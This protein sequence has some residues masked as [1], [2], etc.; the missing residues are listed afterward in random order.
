M[1]K[2]NIIIVSVLSIALGAGFWTV[3]Q[4]RNKKENLKRKMRLSGKADF[5]V[6]RRTREKGKSAEDA[7]EIRKSKRKYYETF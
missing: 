7:W 6:W 2:K 3:F 1:N 5:K 4:Q